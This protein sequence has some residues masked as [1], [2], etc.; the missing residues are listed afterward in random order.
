[1]DAAG[2]LGARVRD[3]ARRRVPYVGVVG[4]REAADDAVALRLRDGR[5]LP[6][7]PVADA[8]GLIGAV[9]AARAA[10]LLPAG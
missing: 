10:E 5:G 4:A 9:V 7:M 1:M 2:S 8:V 3:A 6:P